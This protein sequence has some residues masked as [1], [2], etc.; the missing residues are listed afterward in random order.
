ME[1]KLITLAG[2]WRITKDEENSGRENGWQNALPN[3]E[4]ACITVYDHMPNSDWTMQLSYA[5]VFP[6]YHGYVWYYKTVTALPTLEKGER[7]LLEFERAGYVTEAFFNGIRVGEH[8]GHEEKFA[9]DITDAI[10]TDGENLLAVRC[11]EP[12]AVGEDIDGLKLHEIPNSC[13]GNVN[14]HMLGC[15]DAFCLECVGG[16]LG[17]VHLRAVPDV[18]IEEIGIRPFYET[19]EV[20]VTVRVNNTSKAPVARTFSLTVNAKKA[21]TEVLRTSEALTV[22]VGVSE[23]VLRA[24]IEN[25][26]LWEL[27]MPFLYLASVSVE[28]RD[29]HTAS[30]GFKDFRIK[31]GFF[32][33][34]GKRIF[35]KGAH[36]GVTPAYA[37]TMKALGFNIIRTI[38]RA[39]TEELLDICDEI[40]LL[41]L[42]AAATAWGMTVHE[43]TAEQMETYNVN[44]VRRHRNHPSVAAYCLFNEEKDK[45]PLF[46]CGVGLLPLLRS[47]APDTLFLLHSGRWDGHHMIGSASNPGS[48]AWDTYLGPEGH[49]AVTAREKPFRVD[50]YD[51]WGMGDIHV[52][53]VIPVASYQRNCF[54]RIGEGYNPIF[55]SESG[56]ASQ[57]DPMGGYLTDYYKKLHGALTLAEPK[58]LWD[59]TEEFLE[60]FDLHG[61]YPV[62][63]DLA[64]DTEKLNGAQ[65]TLLYNIF[66]SN[67][68]I[69]GF[70]FTS[71]C[72][73][74]E[75]ALQGNLVIKDSLAYAIQQGH[76]RLRFALFTSERTV[77]ANKPFEIEAVLCNEDVLAPGSYAAVAYIRGENGCVWKKNF[78]LS[79]PENGFGGMPPLA[80]TVLCEEITLPAGEYT[81]SARLLEGGVAYDGDL[82]F[83]VAEADA[84]IGGQ[85]AAWGVPE[86][87][88][89]FLTSRGVTVCPLDAVDFENPPKLLLVGSPENADGT[90]KLASLVEKG[91]NALFADIRFFEKN[92]SFLQTV[93][94]GTA[95]LRDATGTV[96]HHDH[97]CTPH[98]VF[99]GLTGTGV[100]DFDR[101]GITYPD[102]IFEKVEK[103][104][105]TLAAAIRI[106]SSFTVPGLSV[107][108]Y[109]C[110]KGRYVLNNFKIL[111]NITAHPF[112][113]ILLANFVKHYGS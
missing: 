40:G 34:N 13:F 93:A 106:D 23:F 62:A 61:I 44:L 78:T 71:F 67:P 100:L 5:N 48:T 24:K 77:Y 26:R 111:E 59:E 98:P 90:A 22:P 85:I 25:H 56:I 80:A 92:P 60:F 68:M 69:N 8:R 17:A 64:R 39:F 107:G 65:R 3:R 104:T 91:C 95:K 35:L 75:G 87:A 110:G 70:S 66:R 29:T 47:L 58:R 7:L 54:R 46:F 43:K 2:E 101:F 74:N 109:A 53:P 83:T 108:E 94:G 79:Y 112:A 32:F 63:S 49:A 9:F 10:R 42:D 102:F 4:F 88:L 81:F 45:D 37:V 27:D 41:V 36:C 11:F 103:P 16:I 52:Y 97:I 30:F 38:A 1:T 86:A 113:D 72:A 15:A 6:K 76:E 33:L 21:G 57:S 99:S 82:K 14:A 96:Y 19:G 20:E 89:S 105:R 84:E 28:G 18:C 73:E 50:G 31:N 12:R 51:D 55:V